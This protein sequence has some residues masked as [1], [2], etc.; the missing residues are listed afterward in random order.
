MVHGTFNKLSTHK[1]YIHS[2]VF[3]FV[4][5]YDKVFGFRY[6]V[7]VDGPR[8]ESY[9]E[10]Y[11]IGQSLG[12]TDKAELWYRHMKSGAESGNNILPTLILEFK[13]ILIVRLY[14]LNY[15]KKYQG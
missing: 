9:K 6:W 14:P 12:D 11:D 4:V 15:S 2:L 1:L 3:A 10:D 5:F 7:N 8:P 13:L